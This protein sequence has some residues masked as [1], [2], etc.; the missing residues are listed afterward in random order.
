MHLPQVGGKFGEQVAT[1][2]D[3]G[4]GSHYFAPGTQ[5][6]TWSAFD[7]GS[8]DFAGLIAC[9]FLETL[10]Q[11]FLLLSL[12]LAGLLCSRDSGQ[13]SLDAIQCAI[14]IVGAKRF[15]VRPFV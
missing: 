13:Q 14:G 12:N 3:I 7:G 2:S 5:A 15:L 4:L 9:L 10:A 8:S 1:R 6:C 11:Q